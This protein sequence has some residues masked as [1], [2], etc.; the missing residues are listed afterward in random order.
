MCSD[1]GFGAIIEDL[2]EGGDFVDRRRR[3]VYFCAQ[4][5]D[6]SDD[7]FLYQFCERRGYTM[8]QTYRSVKLISSMGS[9]SEGSCTLLESTNPSSA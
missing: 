5:V 9:S 8:S 2:K 4:G 7:D 1:M 6:E 3:V